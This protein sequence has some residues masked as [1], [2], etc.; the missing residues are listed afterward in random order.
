MLSARI[1]LRMRFF[2]GVVLL[3][4]QRLRQK[5]ARSFVS[6]S[7]IPQKQPEWKQSRVKCTENC[8]NDDFC[9]LDRAKNTG[10]V[11]LLWPF[12]AG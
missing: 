11:S 4:C 7:I 1:R 6:G 8:V 10:W 12:A 9:P 5:A 2:I 3:F